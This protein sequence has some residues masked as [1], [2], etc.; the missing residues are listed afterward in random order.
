M[1]QQQ[2]RLVIEAVDKGSI[3]A[4][5]EKMNIS[6]PNASLSIKKLEEEL[7]YSLLR[8]AGSGISPTEQGYRFLKHAQALLNED[9]A[10]RAINAEQRVP[11]LRVGVMNYSPA[12]DAFIRFCG[13][14]NGVDSGNFTCINV[15]YEAGLNLLK[16]RKLDIVVYIQLKNMMPL[17]DAACRENRLTMK[18]YAKVPFCV[19]VRKDHPLILDGTLDGSP[20]G[21]KQLSNYPYIDYLQ[22][23]H[24]I[25]LYNENASVPFGCSSKIHVDERDTRFR[26]ISKT[27]AYSIGTVLSKEKMDKYGIVTVP[28]DLDAFLVS[29]VRKGDEKLT[30]ISRYMEILGEEIPEY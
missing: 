25:G 11:S 26:I 4:A 22:L 23:E 19:R 8:R 6:Q 13:E 7:G 5:A 17:S 9:Q 27:D 30:D 20:K 12:I 16:E 15:S 28:F 14:M 29:I 2:I 24:L 21:F 3:S 10:I 18:K 1:T